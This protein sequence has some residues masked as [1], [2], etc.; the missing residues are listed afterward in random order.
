[1]KKLLFIFG[2][3]PEAIKVA[4]LILSLKKHREEFAVQICVTG[5]HKEM[6][7]Q[8]LDFFG[9]EPDMDLEGM[10]QNQTLFGVTGNT[11]KGLEPILEKF[12][13]DLVV[14]QGDTTSAFVGGL[15]AFYK[16]ILVAHI[17][18][19]LRSGDIYSPFPEEANRTLLS[20][21]SHFHFTPTERASQNLRDEGIDSGIY[22]V[23]NTVI[24]ALMTTHEIVSK[25][26]DE[27]Q[28]KFPEID[29]RRRTVLITGHRR[30]SFGKPFE[31]MC[32][33]IRILAENYSD[34]NFVYPVHLNP[35]VRESVFRILRDIR[36]VF[37]IEPV[38]YPQMVWLLGKS[39]LILTDSGGI[40]EEAPT[41]G[42]PVLVMREV[43]ERIEGIE[44]GTAKLVGTN[45][46]QIIDSVSK[47][48][49]NE[50]SYLEMAQAVN[51]YGDGN[52]CKNIIDVLLQA[53]LWKS[54]G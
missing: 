1:M 24:D 5:Q 21:I 14:V 30:E 27:Y 36:N 23:G 26:D 28:A 37:L 9:I 8:V 39:Y 3:R 33:A 43:T 45:P 40:Q 48:L 32:G 51:P 19:G 29:F 4:P 34:C 35:N 17:E 44:A 31:D 22:E 15:A 6:L 12:A 13:P 52:A 49:E 53:N 2:T 38:D 10:K 11:I 20:R 46:N 18:A 54:R 47:L 41:F 16:Q 50:D 42:K 7:Y 25:K